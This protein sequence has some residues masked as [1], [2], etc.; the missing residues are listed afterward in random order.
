MTKYKVLLT[1]TTTTDLGNWHNGQI[2]F[3]LGSLV[4]NRYIWLNKFPTDAK[5]RDNRRI[6]RATQIANKTI[7]KHEYYSLFFS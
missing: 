4:L 2:G 5:L 7:K 1:T 6:S 3:V